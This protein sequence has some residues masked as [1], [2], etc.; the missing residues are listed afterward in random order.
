MTLSIPRG[1]T[2]LL[3]ALAVVLTRA[4]GTLA[5]GNRGTKKTASK[6]DDVSELLETVRE[7]FDVPALGGAILEGGKL[8]AVGATGLRKSSA[9]GTVTAA[10]RW[11]IGSCGKAMS[12]TLIACLVEKRKLKWEITIGQAFPKLRKSMQPEYLEVTL[13]QLLAHRGGITGDLV[14][15][16]PALWRKLRL[17]SGS[18]RSA[19]SL[20][21]KE[22]LKTP[23]VAEPGTKFIYS[24]AGYS[25]AGAVVEQVLRKSWEEL[26][27]RELFRPLGMRSA[28][29]GAPKNKQP[30]GHAE[31][32]KGGDPVAPG[33]LADNPVALAPA[34][35]IH[36]S[37][38][39]WGRFV[40][41]HVRGIEGKKQRFLSEESLEKLQTPQGES[42]YALG[43]VTAEREWAGGRVLSHSGS[44]TMWFAVVRAAPKRKFAILVTAN[45]G[46]QSEACD[47]AVEALL[48]Y[49][50]ERE[51][52]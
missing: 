40:A 8:V 12:A 36:C 11:H 9:K 43:W 7:R 50:R 17:L 23:P 37:L 51:R 18:P 19:R 6:P 13:A 46:G 16:H 29:F 25:I 34:G 39:D 15:E 47:K 35:T 30:W 14:N 44:N 21:V 2:V 3:L 5:Q 24:N 26:M 27:A 52:S 20:L 33:P 32:S 49:Y 4:G 48:E 38:E 42:K 10:D 1:K 28:G 41:L 31:P 22:L 45:Q